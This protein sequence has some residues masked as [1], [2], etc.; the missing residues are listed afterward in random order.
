MGKRTIIILL[1]L[2]AIQFTNILEFMV[3]MPLGPQ[4]KRIFDI[5]ANEWSG[6]VAAYTYAAFLSGIGSIFIIDKVGRK[7]FL[8][9]AFSG[10]VIGTFLCA[11]SET[12]TMLLASRVVAGLFGGTIGTVILTVVGE[13]V[14]A[15]HRGKAMGIVMTGFSMAAALGVPLGLYFGTV[16]NWH[17]PFYGIVGFGILLLILLLSV[18]PR[19]EEHLK[20]PSNSLQVIKEVFRTSELRFALLFMFTMIVGHF[21]IIP[22]ISPYMVAN[23]GFEEKELTY[24]YLFGG[25]VSFI[26]SPLSGWLTDKYGKLKMYSILGL[27]SLIPVYL[28]THLSATGLVIALTY[29][30]LFFVFNGGRM[31]PGMAL[32]LGAVPPRIRGTYLGIRSSVQM[33]ASGFAATL[34]GVIMIDM[35]DGTYGNYEIV[36][37][38]SI[39]FSVLSIIIARKITSNY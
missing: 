14:P 30:S 18:F 24:I 1:L 2:A 12:Y 28:I 8:L 29:S 38:A 37:Y 26:S 39:V 5:T 16:Y 20:S 17:V 13:L 22:F 11:I 27:I 9:T 21:L 35:P 32:V 10:L 31:V 7:T 34:A 15:E 25:L 36:G 23:V 3:L 33:L 4:L 6:V 19:M